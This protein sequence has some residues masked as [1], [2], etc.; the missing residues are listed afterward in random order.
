M[1][2]LAPVSLTPT[3]RWAI[4]ADLSLLRQIGFS[5]LRMLTFTKGGDP[6]YDPWP[7]GIFLTFPQPTPDELTNLFEFTQMTA[8]FGMTYEVV[9][10]M[11]DHQNLYYQND[12]SSAMYRQFIDAVWNWMWGGLLSRV[13]F[14][15]DLRLGGHDIGQTIV[16]NHRDWLL[17]EWPYFVA[18]CPACG[19]G[20]ELTSG[21]ATLCDRAVDSIAWA[22]ANLT[23]RPP[24]FF[25]CQMYPTSHA[26]LQ[27]AGW[28]HDGVVDWAGMVRDWLARLRAAAGPIPI[29]ADEIGMLLASSAPISSDLTAADQAAFLA[30]AYRVFNAA[31]VGAN[32]WEFADHDGIGRFGL[33]DAAR[34]PRLAVAALSSPLRTATSQG[35]RPGVAYTP[36]E[37]VGLQWLLGP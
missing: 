27:A 5:H 24:S 26:W 4:A 33:F 18:K 32:V 29:H 35:L 22:R 16:Y 9:F 3:Q 36:P 17:R 7:S 1:P 11:A 13:Y 12:V 6:L 30:A 2:A 37:M 20:I 23:E 10:V 34:R 31:Q 21:D 25:G 8:A 14:G 19:I 28:E 15:G